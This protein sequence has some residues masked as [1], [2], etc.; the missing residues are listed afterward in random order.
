[1]AKINAHGAHRVGP[2]LFTEKTRPADPR[3]GD[4]TP[5]VY[6]EAFRLRSDGV[7]QT[8]II[9][10]RP[11]EGFEG[12]TTKHSSGFRNLE[13]VHVAPEV[14]AEDKGPAALRRWLEGRGYAIVEESW[15]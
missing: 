2:T 12:R 11:A 13:R 8:R 9:S 10:T 15:R 14:M 1:M 7:V 4:D 3:I 6:R 5:R